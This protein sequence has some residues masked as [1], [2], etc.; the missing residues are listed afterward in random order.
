[1]DV[2]SIATWKQMRSETQCVNPPI[3]IPSNVQ[4]VGFDVVAALR[5]VMSSLRYI[6]KHCARI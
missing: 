3:Q 2:V 4:R 5:L 1:M 6:L